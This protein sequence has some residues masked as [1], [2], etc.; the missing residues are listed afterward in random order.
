M[1]SSTCSYVNLSLE[2]ITDFANLRA[3]HCPDLSKVRNTEN[4]SLS[5]PGTSEQTPFD[6]SSGS[7]GT[8]LLSRYTLVER[9]YASRS[10]AVPGFT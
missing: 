8:T 6:S 5:S 10:M 7:I 3:T 9:L 1:T 4:A 2:R